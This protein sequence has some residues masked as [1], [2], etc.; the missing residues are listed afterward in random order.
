MKRTW[1]VIMICRSGKE[2]VLNSCRS[3]QKAE[4]IAKHETKRLAYEVQCGYADTNTRF[5]A[6]YC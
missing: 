1:K 2:V 5:E 4:T 6:R 3:Q